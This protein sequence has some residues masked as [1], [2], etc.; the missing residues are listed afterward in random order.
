MEKKKKSGFMVQG[1][2]L[3][4]AGLITR[5]IGMLYRIPLTRIVGKEGMGYYN[6]SYEIYN[7]ALL[8]SCYSVPVAVSKLIADKEGKGEYVNSSRYFRFALILS[9]SIGLTVS[10]LV[11]IFAPQ[12]AEAFKYPSCVIP[13]RVL[14][15]TIFVF[16]IM[17][18][19]RGFFQGK[20]TMVPTALSQIIEQVINAVVSVVAAAYL[21]NAFKDLNEAAAYGAAG[22]TA[23]TLAGAMAALVFLVILLFLYR[24]KVDKS[25]AIDITGKMDESKFIIKA[26]LFTMMPIILSQTIYQVS[27]II[28]SYIFSNFMNKHGYTETERSIFWEAYSNRYKWMYNVPVAIASAFGVSIVPAL[29]SSYAKNDTEGIK[30]KIASAVKFNM[31]IAFPAAMGLGFLSQPIL[32][33]LLGDV[34]DNLGPR[35]LSLGC[36]AVVFFALSTLTNGVLQGISMM[37]KPVTH[38]LIALIIHIIAVFIGLNTFE[39]ENG[40]YVMVICNM[41]YGL[42]VCALNWWS[43]A[44][45]L[46]YKQEIKRTF[47]LPA[48]CALLMGVV[49][50]YT[51]EFVYGYTYSMALALIPAF[52]VAVLVYAVLI[53]LTKTVTE[54]EL[55]EMPIGKKIVR[56]LKK[57]RLIR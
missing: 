48:I 27:G 35:L 34:T 12:I 30:K 53:L 41:L 5:F 26:L 37:R 46:N 10:L 25:E 16:S 32:V 42:L 49:T 29:S 15:P 57:I 11:F 38:S 24:K 2:I 56:I 7:I 4:A 39:S 6:N 44:K 43:I 36:M 23:G 3:A 18:V 54:D 8:I 33:L 55:L 22:G 31:L 9:S 28:D 47:L 19:I 17:G 14:T 20:H 45:A 13:L 51:Y 40:V 1:G 50:D 21:I 52:I